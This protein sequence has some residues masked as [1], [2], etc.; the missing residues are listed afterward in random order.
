MKTP[1]EKLLGELYDYARCGCEAIHGIT[2]HLTSPELLAD[3]AAQL[4]IYSAIGESAQRMLEEKSYSPASFPL[5]EKLGVRGGVLM[6]TMGMTDQAELARV[7]RVSMRDSANRLRSTVADLSGGCDEDAL[8]L[9]QRLLGYT[10]Y[11]TE[12]LGT[13]RCK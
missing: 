11:E 10:L 3:T 1:T 4:E 7:L 5:H 12:K 2:P 9:G 8:A 6:E 13:I